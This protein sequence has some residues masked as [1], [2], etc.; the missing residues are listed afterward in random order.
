MSSNDIEEAMKCRFA[1]SKR[2]EYSHRF[3]K[4]ILPD[5]RELLMFGT[6][7]GDPPFL[8][9]QRFADCAGHIYVVN[10]CAIGINLVEGLPTEFLGRG[11]IVDFEHEFT[12]PAH[13]RQ[14]PKGGH[15]V[16]DILFGEKVEI[17]WEWCNVCNKAQVPSHTEAS[18]C[19]GKVHPQPPTEPCKCCGT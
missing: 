12:C 13:T 5:G 4:C 9:A 16:A 7:Q 2:G 3:G 15:T 6:K 8:G 17:L 18:K 11:R 10:T 14:H 1:A 19:C